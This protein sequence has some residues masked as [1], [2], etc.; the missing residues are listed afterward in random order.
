M[1]DYKKSVIYP[2]EQMGSSG[3]YF[4]VSTYV[5]SLGYFFKAE[6]KLGLRGTQQ[7]LS[8][9][10]HFVATCSH[11]VIPNCQTLLRN[12]RESDIVQQ[13]YGRLWSPLLDLYSHL[14]QHSE[15][16]HHRDQNYPATNPPVYQNIE[17]ERQHTMMQ[18]AVCSQPMRELL[19][20]H[21]RYIDDANRCHHQGKDCKFKYV[22]SK[23]GMVP[24]G[25]NVPLPAYLFRYEAEGQADFYYPCN[26][27]IGVMEMLPQDG[28]TPLS[29]HHMLLSAYKSVESSPQCPPKKRQAV[30]FNPQSYHNSNH[31]K[32]FG[33]NRYKCYI[34]QD[35]SQQV[36]TPCADT[37]ES[38]LSSF[39]RERYEQ[40]LTRFQPSPMESPNVG[41][42]EIPSPSTYFAIHP[43]IPD[44]PSIAFK[45]S[46]SDI[47]SSQDS[48]RPLVRTFS[49][50]APTIITHDATPNNSPESSLDT[51]ETCFRNSDN[52]KETLSHSPTQL[53]T[54]GMLG[55]NR[56]EPLPAEI[57]KKAQSHVSS[58]LHR[59]LHSKKQN[60]IRLRILGC[61]SK[62]DQRPPVRTLKV[63]KEDFCLEFVH[64]NGEQ[65]RSF[66]TIRWKGVDGNTAKEG[67]KFIK[68]GD[69]GSPLFVV[70][71][72][73]RMERL[74]L[75][76]TINSANTASRVDFTRDVISPDICLYMLSQLTD[77][78][79]TK[80][81]NEEFLSLCTAARKRI[82][83][84]KKLMILGQAK[85][86]S[87]KEQVYR[88]IKGLS[89]AMQDIANGR[90][91][92]LGRNGL[93]KFE[94]TPC[95]SDC[96]YQHVKYDTPL[97]MDRDMWNELWH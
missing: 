25:F 56:K 44:D 43:L 95:I 20:K 13:Q 46:A 65:H 89:H 85:D 38:S 50:T 36:Y 69:S 58:F 77:I 17:R 15:H 29:D 61:C 78:L 73:N 12:V 45:G 67:G 74:I 31:V 75:L 10:K 24:K 51:T 90:G 3:E 35:D 71:K 49:T 84:S 21:L 80:P 27:D 2:E 55:K 5:G 83:M 68:K 53:K 91:L 47:T 87:D 57:L 42:Y 22:C 92:S 60:K 9:N 64:K 52:K 88:D 48:S 94:M 1:D 6:L 8:Y 54:T 11:C 97:H 81:E 96:N 72:E 23:F 32:M 18:G 33:S 76:G 34:N 59:Y 62:T 66:P 7:T 93:I 79:E 39:D 86:I 30:L 26:V 19:N 63:K 4:N 82:D 37:P 28:K 14:W 70:I 40:Y 16:E 41:T